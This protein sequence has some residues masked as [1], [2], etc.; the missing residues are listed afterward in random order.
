M[1]LT[2]STWGGG[3]RQLLD[4]H[5]GGVTPDSTNTDKGREGSKIPKN[6]VYVLNGRP[7]TAMVEHALDDFVW[8]PAVADDELII[9]GV[10]VF[11]LILLELEPF[12]TETNSLI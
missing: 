4:V 9:E 3:F 11:F 12:I 6:F 10:L 5:K 8:I 1:K 2:A 7:L